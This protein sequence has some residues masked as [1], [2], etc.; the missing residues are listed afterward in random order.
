MMRAA[1]VCTWLSALALLAGAS[2]PASAAEP[3]PAPS[4]P[5]AAAQSKPKPRPA[6]DSGPKAK[7]PAEQTPQCVWTGSH[8]ITLLAREDVVAAGEYLR[9]YQTFKCPAARLADALGCMVA[10][11]DVAAGPGREVTERAR[12]CWSNPAMRFLET[13]TGEVGTP[14]AK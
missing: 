14:A 6:A 3:Y 13:P 5:N 12:V 7:L 8:V 9:F 1:V 10:A 11:Q 4:R 2:V